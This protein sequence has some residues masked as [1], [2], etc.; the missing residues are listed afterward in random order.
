MKLGILSVLFLVLTLVVLN[1]YYGLISLVL[2]HYNGQIVSGFL[3]LIIIIIF[4]GLYYGL[5]MG[6]MKGLVYGFL[7][8]DSDIENKT[9]P[10]QGIRQSIINSVLVIL[11]CYLSFILMLLILQLLSF[12]RIKL[13]LLVLQNTSNQNNNLEKYLISGWQPILFG[14]I[15]FATLLG[16][17][18]S[19]ISAIKHFV[20]RIILWSNGC[21]PWNYAKF[22]NYCTNR[23]FLQRVGGSYRF[24]HDLLRQ[25]F[26]NSYAQNEKRYE[27][28]LTSFDKAIQLNSKPAWAWGRQGRSLLKLK[29][30]E[31]ALVSFDKAIQLNSKNA[32]AWGHQG[33]L[34][35]ELER[36]EEALVSFD[37]AIQLDS[38]DAWAWYQQ[39]WLL[40]KLERYEEALI[41]F[42]KAIQLDSKDAWAWGKQGRSLLKLERYEE[43]LVSFDKAIQLDSKD[44]WAWGQQG[45]LLLE[46]ERYEEA[47]VSFDKAIQLD[48]KDAWAWGQQGLVLHKLERY[49]EALISFDKAIK[50][51][52]K[53]DLALYNLSCSYA[54]QGNIELTIDNLQ[55]AIEL[56]TN[57][58]ESAKTDYDFANIREHEL[59]KK[60]VDK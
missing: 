36:Y 58:K 57:W 6:L 23:L 43:A 19:G 25:H 34:L 45:R 12:F 5:I 7:R 54:I 10:N 44:A 22:L 8:S 59:F 49:E 38:K 55:R 42:D 21:A 48:S 30:Y 17:R 15:Y 26:A 35:L 2:N 13:T 53:N 32:W 51:D 4:F 1:S 29:R 46:L 56:N 31:E 40:L 16:I 47:L 27:E 11:V 39:G 33:W 9:A 52:S 3:V 37:K 20:V 60:L 24:M 28:A 41:S 50:L 14:G 18:I